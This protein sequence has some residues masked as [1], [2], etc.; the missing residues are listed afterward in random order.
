LVALARRE[1]R[2]ATVRAALAAIEGSAD[3]AGVRVVLVKPNFVSTQRQLAATHVDAV[4][5]VLD[6]LRDRFDG[7]VTIGEGPAASPARQA[8]EAYGYLEV[9]QRYG[10]RLMDLNADGTL[11]IQVYDW[12]LRPMTLHLARTVVEADYRIVVGPP[13][14]HDT[15]IVTLAIKNLVMGAL[16][17]AGAAHENGRGLRISDDLVRMVPVWLQH[18]RLAELAKRLI[19]RPGRGS[20][21]M[22]MHQ[23]IPVIN[24]NLALIASA[25]WPQLAV[26]DGWRGMEG[27][28]PTMGDPVAWGIALAGTDALAVDVLCAHLMGFDPLQIGYLQH[29]REMGLGVGELQGIGVTGDASPESVRRSFTPH[30]GTGRQLNWRMAGVGGLLEP[31]RVG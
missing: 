21:K 13:K 6:W 10:A 17:N 20:S 8:F 4:A 5:A 30:P 2:A 16:V 15:V 1:T 3:L 24:L 11:P 29:C 28:G 14:T 7:P 25:V 9:A 18:S 26:I 12:K 23:S 27:A 22:A 31:C 19:A